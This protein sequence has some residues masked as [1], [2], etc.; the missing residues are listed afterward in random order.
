MG[1]KPAGESPI[2][3][4]REEFREAL[5]QVHR[6]LVDFLVPLR[7]WLDTHAPLEA[8]DIVGRFRATF[9]DK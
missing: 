2:V 3:F 5:N 1:N 8:A 9:L 6:D 7:G 4:G